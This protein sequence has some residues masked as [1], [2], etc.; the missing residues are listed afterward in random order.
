[1]L[2]HYFLAAWLPK[3]NVEREFY[4]KKVGDKLYTAGIIVPV[5]TVEPGKTGAVDMPLYAGPQEVEKLA[6]LAPG[7]DLV[8]DYGWLTIIAA[9][10]FKVL[11]IIHRLVS[12]WG[13]AIIL[14]TVLIKLI[15]F[16]LQSK[17]SRSMAQMNIGAKNAKLKEQY[18]D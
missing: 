8:V 4:T 7:L 17:A 6:K 5:G 9:P 18:G 16:P 2:Q 10:I 15:F 13:V 3:G 12:N 1:M 11:H 14:L